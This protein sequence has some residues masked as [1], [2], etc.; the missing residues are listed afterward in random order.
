[1]TI[2]LRY[3]KWR[4]SNEKEQRNEKTNFI[5]GDL[6]Q[7]ILLFDEK[8]KREVETTFGIKFKKVLTQLNNL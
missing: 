8:K 6:F 1:M 2:Q 4:N 7:N 3:D 5:D